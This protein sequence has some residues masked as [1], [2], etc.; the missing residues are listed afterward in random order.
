MVLMQIMPTGSKALGIAQ[1]RWQRF[2]LLHLPGGI[3]RQVQSNHGTTFSVSLSVFPLSY[4]HHYG[5]QG[6]LGSTGEG[7]S[8]RCGLLV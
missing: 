3:K 4:P 1:F 8:R 6:Q 7:R 2:P 5:R